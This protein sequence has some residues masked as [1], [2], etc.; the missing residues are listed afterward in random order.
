M[1]FA[2]PCSAQHWSFQAYGTDQGLTN[3]TTIALHQDREGYLWVSTEGGLFRYDGDRFQ[4]FHVG[5]ATKTGTSN[6]IYSSADGQ[7]WTGST[8]GLFRWTGSAF[9]PVAG[10]EDVELASGQAIGADAA[11]LYVATPAG[12]RSTPLRGGAKPRLISPKPSYSVLVTSGQTVWY[13]CGP[14]ICTL[15][16]DGREQEWGAGQGV[17]GGPFR[18]I[19]EDTAGRLWIRSSERV[20]VRD[21]GAP[22][23]RA[24]P[25]LEGL[26]SS[27]G[28]L[29]EP[30]R[31]GEILIPHNAGL[32]ICKGDDCRNYSARNGLERAEALTAI[33]DR[34]GSLWIGYSGHG[35]ARW[36]GRDQWQSFAEEEGLANPGIWRI[37]RD[38]SGDLWIGTTRGLFH[39]S[40]KG[41]AWRFRPTEAVG[42]LSVYGLAAGPDGALW[43]GTFQSGANG[44]VRYDPRTGQR[45]VYP[46]AQPVTRFS[47]SGIDRRRDRD[48]LGGDARRASCGSRPAPRQLE[49]VPLPVDGASVSEVRST[50]QG[51]FVA[52]RKGLYIRA[53]S[54]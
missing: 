1:L 14:L 21:P 6:S 31:L 26:D 49:P 38:A 27:H 11:N 13:S 43:L 30:D 7:L 53:G 48:G 52:C 22:A 9:T 4:P 16:P 25:H 28:T 17:S 45:R 36:L 23:F 8:A 51:L 42:E 35:L 32:T 3:P 41:G 24:V 15:Q 47:I 29:L 39:G 37:V 5:S 2:L 50:A 12:L 44:L 33:E 20:L 40:Q 54:R 34:E 46:P 18:S 10:F 19:A